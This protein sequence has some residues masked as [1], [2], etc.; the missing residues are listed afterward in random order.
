MRVVVVGLG[1]A[2]AELL[3]VAARHALE[4]I[5][6][7]LVR[8]ARH[9]AVADLARTGITFEPLDAIYETAG[10]L[11]EVYPRIVD[12]V[13]EAAAAHGEVCYAVPGSPAVAERSVALLTQAAARGRFGLE[14]VPGLSFADLAW[15]RLGVDPLGGARVVDGREAAV[16]LAGAE[17][18]VLIAQCD[19]RSVLTEVKLALLDGLPPQHPVRV[20]VHLGLPDEQVFEVPLA[21]LDRQVAPDHLTSLYVEIGPG[22]VA[23]EL[24]RLVALAQRLRGPGGCPWDAAQTHHS[25]SRYLLEEAYE[26]AEAIG[27]LPRD[28]PAGVEDLGA[29][30]RLEDELGD[31]LFQVILHAVLAREAGAFTIA[32]VANRIHDKL[33]HRHPHVFGDVEVAGA[34]EVTANWEQIKRREKG[35]TSLVEGLPGHLPALLAVH[36][37]YRKAAAVGLEPGGE[38]EVVARL[39]ATLARVEAEPGEEALADL[40]AAVVALARDRGIDAESLLHRWAARFRDR[41]ARMEALAARAGIDLGRAEPD[42]VAALW[43]EAAVPRS[44]GA[45]T[46]PSP[47]P[48]P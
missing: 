26:V 43:I 3:T 18:G 42:R 11:E 22:P 2:G 20:L 19:H 15:A 46:P 31:L 8:T 44:P 33:V 12:A 21:E 24:A 17:G 38:A 7:R 29:Y 28:A 47:D 34:D 4:R 37:L 45:T 6:R 1:P 48:A 5:P 27:D 25:L 40:L 36:K 35:G 16:A 14:V 32:D 10:S 41:F 39:H 23:G 13:V 30:D 9:P